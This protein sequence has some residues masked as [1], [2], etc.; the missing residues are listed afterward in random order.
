MI[1]Q[2]Q[3]GTIKQELQLEITTLQKLKNEVEEELNLLQQQKNELANSIGDL[4]SKKHQMEKATLASGQCEVQSTWDQSCYYSDDEKQQFE[5]SRFS[6]VEI[7][8]EFN[9]LNSHDSVSREMHHTTSSNSDSSMNYDYVSQVR[10]IQPSQEAT[11][12]TLLNS[13]ESVEDV[14]DNNQMIAWKSEKSYLE[15]Q[16][17]DMR[18]TLT[19]LQSEV[20]GLENRK[21]IL[22]ALGET[23]SSD[24]MATDMANS[25]EVSFEADLDFSTPGTIAEV[26][27]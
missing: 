15:S 3:L 10:S 8:H 24:E 27:S 26:I 14:K 21:T 2:E 19:Q 6:A 11:T 9:T 1:F 25:Y 7:R 23:N 13:S 22:E 12:S 20:T 17:Y 18:V 4:Q 16:I 5:D